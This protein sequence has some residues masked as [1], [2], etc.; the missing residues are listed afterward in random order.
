MRYLAKGCCAALALAAQ[1]AAFV[2]P[3]HAGACWTER[4]MPAAGLRQLDVMLMVGSLQCR[5]GADDYRAE[6]DRFLSRH[7]AY[8]GGANHR[9]LDE[10]SA[11]LG[12]L[13]AMDALDHASVRMANHY[14]I[15]RTYG[16]HELKLVAA[17]LANGPDEELDHAADVL[18]GPELED[19]GCPGAGV[20]V[21]AAA[22]VAIPGNR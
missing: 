1:I 20:A 4:T 13:A 8:L 22:P 15:R 9:I 21:A 5:T 19:G 6:Y 12:P 3:A 11:R 7:R 14:G 18:V 16:C 17:A 10:F 2:A